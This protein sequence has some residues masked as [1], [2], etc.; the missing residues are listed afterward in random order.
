VIVVRLGAGALYLALIE[1]LAVW[2]SPKQVV[3]PP[4]A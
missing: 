4:P 1:G 2:R 3:A